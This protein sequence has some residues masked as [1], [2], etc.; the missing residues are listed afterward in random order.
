MNSGKKAGQNGPSGMITVFF[1]A[2]SLLIFGFFCTLLEGGRTARIRVLLR[3]A[4]SSAAESV[5]AA[6]HTDVLELYGL[7]MCDSGLYEDAWTD[8]ARSYLLHY[9]APSEGLLF[10]ADDSIRLEELTVTPDL[11]L[12]LTDDHGKIFA[13]SVL[14]YMRSAGLSVI[15]K[16]VLARLGVGNESEAGELSGTVGSFLSGDSFSLGDIVGNL[17]DLKQQAEEIR[18]ARE[19]EARQAA[20]NGEPPE[21]EPPDP[22]E[23]ELERSESGNGFLNAVRALA[24]NG[25]LALVVGDRTVFDETFRADTLPSSLSE[26]W[27]GRNPGMGKTAF[28][29]V[30]TFLLGE[31][32][33]HTMN[34]L[35]APDRGYYHYE[36]EYVL[37]G[38]RTGSGAL[39]AVAG[40]LALIRTGFNFAYLLTDSDKLLEA[41]L[42]G[43]SIASAVY[44]PALAPAFK[45]L[46][47]AAWAVAESIADVRHLMKGEKVPVFKTAGSWRLQALS[48]AERDYSDG[49]RGLVYEDYLRL[50]FYLGDR[51]KQSYR[52]M[53]VIENRMRRIDPGFRMRSMMTGCRLTAKA[54]V[55]NMFL[56]LPVFRQMSGAGRG[57]RFKER[58]EYYYGRR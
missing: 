14:T 29:A 36:L 22:T 16:E 57:W 4:A 31:Y 23:E 3:Q 45:W 28:G 1:A 12:R 21:E 32:A 25:L 53:D 46:L 2:V 44:A 35:T 47:V 7:L 52:M 15:V 39:A 20:E 34:S 51:E 9:L 56:S 10:G 38:I 19:E 48:L 13:D 17:Q 6:Y 26:N 50:L 24:E 41:E 40:L 54:K 5:L 49:G 8:D 30:D 58:A 55:G 43:T 37:T 11:T 33:F 18:L 27:K 42:V